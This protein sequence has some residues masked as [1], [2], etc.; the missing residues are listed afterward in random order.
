MNHE[1]PVGRRVNIQFDTVHAQGEG[2]GKSR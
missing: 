1:H 2:M